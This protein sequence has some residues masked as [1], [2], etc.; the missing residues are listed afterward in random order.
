[1]SREKEDEARLDALRHWQE[2]F[3]NGTLHDEHA[4]FVAGVLAEKVEQLEGAKL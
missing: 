4:E 1:M 2:M 3:L